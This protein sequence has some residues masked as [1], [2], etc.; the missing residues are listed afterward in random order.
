MANVTLSVSA[1]Q[2]SIA[3][4]ALVAVLATAGCAA[5][6]GDGD[7]DPERL[8]DKV[9]QRLESIETMEATTSW[10]IRAG[11]S[12]DSFSVRVA[13][14]DPGKVNLTYPDPRALSGARTVNAGRSIVAVNPGA[15]T[16]ARSNDLASRA[17]LSRVFLNVAGI[18]SATFE[19]NETIDGDAATATPR[20]VHVPRGLLGGLRRAGALQTVLP[21]RDGE[22]GGPLHHVTD[23]AA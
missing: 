4:L 9:D 15:G 7:A 19:G 10:E 17:S 12:S 18:R 23:R 6:F 22:P 8:A 2:R 13:Y 14:A 16:Y 1:L 5:P 3:V 11:N 20:R 21:E